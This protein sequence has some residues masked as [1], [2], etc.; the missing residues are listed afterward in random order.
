MKQATKKLERLR[1]RQKLATAGECE[2]RGGQVR[3]GW[4]RRRRRWPVDGS[5]VIVVIEILSGFAIIVSKL[6]VSRRG[7]LTGKLHQA[8]TE[9][10]REVEDGGG[11]ASRTFCGGLDR[12]WPEIRC[13]RTVFED[14]VVVVTVAS[15]TG[16]AVLS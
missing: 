1:K 11:Q 9:A 4:I 2:R 7:N 12:S 6:L 8:R 5:E 16:I 3:L 14:V 13:R 10:E 15:W